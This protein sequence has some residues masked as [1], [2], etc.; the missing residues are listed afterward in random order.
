MILAD[1]KVLNLI[2]STNKNSSTKITITKPV[3]NISTTTISQVMDQIVTF[4][5]LDGVVDKK[6]A[7]YV[8]TLSEKIHI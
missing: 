5:T 3:L 7:E 6:A 4:G 8:T 1:R 2:F